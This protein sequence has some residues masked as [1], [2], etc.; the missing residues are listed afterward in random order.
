M[1]ICYRQKQ[2]ETDKQTIQI[3]HTYRQRQANR[4]YKQAVRH[5]YTHNCAILSRRSVIGTLTD[6]GMHSLICDRDEK[7]D[8]FVFVA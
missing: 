4:L 3:R 6:L 7:D 5:T 1:T 8:D 2:T